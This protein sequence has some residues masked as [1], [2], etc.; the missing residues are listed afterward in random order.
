MMTEIDLMGGEKSEFQRMIE[1]M[2]ANREWLDRNV[3]E[4]TAQYNVGE[5]VGIMDK[6]VIAKGSNAEEVKAAMGDKFGGEA[7]IICIPDRE[8][9]QPI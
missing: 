2:C 9:P 1:R 4:L 8:I 5:W 6:Q 3:D 7:L